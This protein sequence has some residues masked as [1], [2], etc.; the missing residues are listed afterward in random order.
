MNWSSKLLHLFSYCFVATHQQILPQCTLQRIFLYLMVATSVRELFL[1]ASIEHHFEYSGQ[2][3]ACT[4]IAFIYNLTRIVLFVFTIG[5]MIHP[6]C[7][8]QYVAKGSTVPQFLQSKCCRVCLEGSYVVLSTVIFAYAS[9][10]YFT[11][12]YGLAEARCWIRALDEH[13]RLI[14]S[15]LLRHNCY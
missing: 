7:M 11:H 14:L 13:C 4:W 8:I 12:N 5:I 10:P 2:E 9:I 6:F 3:T 15:G 1:A